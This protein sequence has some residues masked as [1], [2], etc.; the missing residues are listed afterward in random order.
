MSDHEFEN[1]Y[2]NPN[3]R[4]LGNIH[5]ENSAAKRKQFSVTIPV[6]Q[7]DVSTS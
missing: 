3:Y 2:V 7:A 4:T 6:T 1:D 5:G